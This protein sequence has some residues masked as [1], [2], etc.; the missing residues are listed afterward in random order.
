MTDDSKLYSLAEK[1]FEAF[2]E[3]LIERNC[4]VGT[5]NPVTYISDEEGQTLIY[6]RGEYAEELI[7]GINKLHGHDPLKH[8]A[9]ETAIQLASTPDLITELC[10]RE[11]VT[12]VP[13]HV[14]HCDLP[15]YL[16]GVPRES[17]I[18]VIPGVE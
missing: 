10:S 12:K 8:L 15:A 16:Y 5:D 2:N 3:F 14:D 7:D 17:R 13:D 11:G 18:L 1:V 9:F 6:T 4:V